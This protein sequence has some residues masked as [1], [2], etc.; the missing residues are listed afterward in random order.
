M[1]TSYKHLSRLFEIAIDLAAGLPTEERFE[2]LLAAAREVIP[3]DAAAILKLKDNTLH[4]VAQVGLA[5]EAM[6]RRFQTSAHPRLERIIATSGVTH[7]DED[8]PLPDPYDGLI[9]GLEGRLPVHSCMGSRLQ[10]DG[11]TWG[12]I[13]FDAMRSAAFE[14]IS[15]QLVIAFSELAA[16][17]ASAADYIAGLEQSAVREHEIN[18]NLLDQFIAPTAREMVGD[19]PAMRALHQELEL[20]AP[21]GLAVMISGETGSGK[22]LAA[23]AV[24]LGSDRSEQPMVYLNCAALPEQLV[25]SE[26]FGHRKGAFTGAVRDY[27]GKFEL[28]H[29]GTLFLDEIG[30]LPLETQAK[31]L[32]T[33]QSGE[34][35]PLGS[36]KMLIVDVRIIAATN[37]DLK[38]EVLEGRFREDLFHRLCVYPIRVPPLRER[39]ADIAPLAG[40]FIENL[41]VQMGLSGIHLSADAEL[42]LSSYDWPGNVRELEHLISRALLR[43]RQR[44]AS[45]PTAITAADF[46]GLENTTMRTDTQTVTP[47]RSADEP[48]LAYLLDQYQSQVIRDRVASREGNWSSA[49]QS[50][51]LHR[52]NLHRLAKRLGIK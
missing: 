15:D 14:G 13:T 37:R 34:V 26:L 21:T 39:T 24:H 16:A 32:R 27:T 28:A 1:T 52:S 41:S 11:N 22:E 19:S 36:E 20:V 29:Q 5:R 17:A 51:G 31:L 50:L 10:V 43:V 9:E 7:F 12:V 2:R 44:G 3:C 18:R 8:S 42:A 40:F 4:P 23:R 33:L 38:N 30:E 48:E 6:G 35:Q 47:T 25:E 45:G 49:A 46:D